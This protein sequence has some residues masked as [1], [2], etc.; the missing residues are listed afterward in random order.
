M[1]TINQLVRKGR[2]TP[3]EK[4]K[5]RAL[6][7]C[8]QRRGV[9][10]QVMTRTPKKPNSALRKVAKVRLTNGEEVIA[11]IGGEGRAVLFSR[12]LQ[13]VIGLRG[14]IP[15][16]QITGADHHQGGCLYPSE[17]VDALPGGDTESLG[18]V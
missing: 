14:E 5:S 8:P 17:G 15:V 16:L 12:D 18:G 7:S 3:E 10:L 4:S 2:I 9:C 11:Y 13:P 1:P 6:H